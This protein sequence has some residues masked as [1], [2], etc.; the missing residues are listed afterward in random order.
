MSTTP[1][2]A[3]SEDTFHQCGNCDWAGRTEELVD[4]CDLEQ[5]IAANEIVPSGQCPKCGAL[6]YEFKPTKDRCRNDGRIEQCGFCKVTN[7]APHCYAYADHCLVTE[8]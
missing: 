6:T 8:A 1:P 5:R 4:I 3:T 2:L 7:R